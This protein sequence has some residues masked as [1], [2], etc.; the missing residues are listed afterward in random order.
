MHNTLNL[1]ADELQQQ[2]ATLGFTSVCQEQKYEAMMGAGSPKV[3]S[4]SLE[5]RNPIGWILT[6]N[7]VRILHQRHES[8]D[9]TLLVSIIQEMVEMV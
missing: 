5:K 8:T 3:D 4:W 1:K 7:R 6:D 2:K 9:Q